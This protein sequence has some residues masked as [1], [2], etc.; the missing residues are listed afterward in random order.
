MFCAEIDWSGGSPFKSVDKAGKSCSAPRVHHLQFA[1]YNNTPL[2]SGLRFWCRPRMLLADIKW[3]SCCVY[4]W[5]W[6]SNGGSVMRP[7]ITLNQQ[8]R[9]LLGNK[10]YHL[11][12]WSWLDL[13]HDIS[14]CVTHQLLRLCQKL[15]GAFPNSNLI[16]APAL[17]VVVL[18]Q[19]T[20]RAIRLPWKFE[21]K[22]LQ[23]CKEIS[24]WSNEEDENDKEE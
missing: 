17:P 20:Q 22:F 18:V 24:V 16:L 9:Y 4:I 7:N 10:S 12:P 21:V 19:V 11:H 1:F 14:N 5:M 3:F 23:T 8:Q 15:R 6:H 2:S 13:T